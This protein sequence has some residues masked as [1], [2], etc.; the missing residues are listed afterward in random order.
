M[1]GRVTVVTGGSRGFGAATCRRLAAASHEFVL[2]HQAASEA[3]ELTAEAV[4]AN[5]S[6]CVTVQMDT[7]AEEDVDRMFDVA[8]EL[9]QVTGLVNNAAVTGP[10]SR[11]VDVPADE[12]LRVFEVDV[13]GYLLCARRAAHDMAGH[14]GA[15]VN[16]SS[17]AATLGSPGEYVHYAA[18]KAAV[19]ALTI[20]LA[21]ELAADRIRVTLS[22]QGS[23]GPT[24]TPTLNVP[25]R[26]ASRIPLGRAGEPDEIAGAICWLLGPDASYTTGAILR[27]AGGL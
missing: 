27:I 21:K 6:R 10:V 19:D 20:G 24:S 4:R 23:Y 22:L 8:A 16:V 25:R 15:I 5:G 2:G 17:A 7:S 12:L 9:G 14:G 13:V 3:A 26:L 18:A 11:L 1:N